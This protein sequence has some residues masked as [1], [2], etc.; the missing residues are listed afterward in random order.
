MRGAT[1]SSLALG[2]IA[3]NAIVIPDG[4]ES[5]SQ[6]EAATQGIDAVTQSIKLS[7]PEC[8]LNGNF[9][10]DSVDGT[11]DDV[12]AL[13]GPNSL[14]LNFTIAEDRR[15]LGLNG[16]TL[17]PPSNTLGRATV[18]QAPSAA[19]W[20]DIKNHIIHDYVSVSADSV[21]IAE[22]VITPAGDASIHLTY[23]VIDIDDRPITVA[24]ARVNMLKSSTGDLEI[25]GIDEVVRLTQEVE[26]KPSTQPGGV[27]VVDCHGL[28]LFVCKIKAAVTAKVQSI[29]AGCHGMMHRKPATNDD[30]EV[31]AVVDE[32]A[33][34]DDHLFGGMPRPTGF[35]F[36]SLLRG[37]L[38]VVIPIMAGFTIG[39]TVSV[40]GMLI[41]RLVVFLWATYIR[42][43]SAYVPLGQDEEAYGSDSKQAFLEDVDDEPLPLYEDSPA[44]EESAPNNK[45]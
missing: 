12:W 20:Q 19:S 18:E 25:L 4:T 34:P 28:P 17:F 26:V 24:G 41:G 14:V 1:L 16:L 32:L 8:T 7:C 30:M 33:Q 10:M 5:T 2:A 22:E 38:M 15:S 13:G 6:Q 44:Y 31:D 43:D 45:A 23:Q 3:A 42:K 39:M 27:T 37:V 35:D 9:G 11:T 36:Q 21:Y 40:V 29:K